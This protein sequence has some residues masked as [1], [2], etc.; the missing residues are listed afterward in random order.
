MPHSR[1]MR[2][3]GVEGLGGS[4]EQLAKRCGLESQPTIDRSSFSQ[5]PLSS[6]KRPK[7]Q[8]GFADEAYFKE[9]DNRIKPIP[10]S[11]PAQRQIQKIAKASH[12]RHGKGGSVQALLMIPLSQI[13]SSSTGG[14][15]ALN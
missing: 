13:H 4:N 14:K 3:L 7:N 11:Q 12:N 15:P 2:Q 1:A 8:I 9:T 5:I 10:V 6:S